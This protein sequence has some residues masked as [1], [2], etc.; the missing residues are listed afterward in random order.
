MSDTRICTWLVYYEISSCV[1]KS[2]VKWGTI[3]I[4][5]AAEALVKVY[6]VVQ[7]AANIRR[8]LI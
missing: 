5:N 6:I 7:P 2:K 4:S 8:G 1:I 3:R